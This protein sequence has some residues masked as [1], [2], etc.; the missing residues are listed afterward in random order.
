M[1]R[2]LLREVLSFAA[3]CLRSVSVN[4]DVSDRVLEILGALAYHYLFAFDGSF[5]HYL[6]LWRVLVCQSLTTDMNF[7]TFSKSESAL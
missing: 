3:L 7:L 2:L 5:I 1:I 4:I 6:D